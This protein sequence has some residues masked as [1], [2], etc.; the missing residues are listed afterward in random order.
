MLFDTIS[1]DHI[2]AF[3]ARDKVKKDILSSVISKCKYKK[4]EKNSSGDLTDEDVLKIIEK[5]IKELDEEI[6][7]FK[8]AGPNYQDRVDTLTAQKDILAAYL[9]EKLTE[10]EIL[11]IISKLEDKSLPSVMKY[12][13]ANYAGKCDM[14]LVSKLAKK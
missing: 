4:V 14:G 11:N 7:S 3:K 8:N 2:T 5:T 1:K 13:K 10:E 9:P 6:T 12:F